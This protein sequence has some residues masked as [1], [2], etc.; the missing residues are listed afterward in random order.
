MLG[1]G[2]SGDWDFEEEIG[3][4]QVARQFIGDTWQ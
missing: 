4:S 3:N 1:K 2:E